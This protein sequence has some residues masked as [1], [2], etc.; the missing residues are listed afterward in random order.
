MHCEKL[1]NGR[2]ALVEKVRVLVFGRIKVMTVQVHCNMPKLD[3][4]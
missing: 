1:G 2:S 4:S 3:L